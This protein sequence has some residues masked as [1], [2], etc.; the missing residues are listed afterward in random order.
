[1]MYIVTCIAFVSIKTLRTLVKRTNP[2]PM[3]TKNVQANIKCSCSSVLTV[4]SIVA[5]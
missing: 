5:S 4:K 2:H 1:M 3:V